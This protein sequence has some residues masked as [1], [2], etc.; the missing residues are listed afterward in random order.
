MVSYHLHSIGL[1]SFKSTA[2]ITT[3]KRE[4]WFYWRGV[5]SGP[6]CPRAEKLPLATLVIT[7]LLRS[8]SCLRHFILAPTKAHS[9]LNFSLLNNLSNTAIPLIQPNFS[10]SSVTGVMG[11]HC[12]VLI[13]RFFT[14][15]LFKITHQLAIVRMRKILFCALMKCF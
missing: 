10:G 8:R 11:F 7:L 2:K 1:F 13:Q 4:S 9:V 5:N 3:G 14:F 12:I 15:Y 6:T